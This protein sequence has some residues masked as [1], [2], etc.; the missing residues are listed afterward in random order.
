MQALP[1]SLCQ[2]VSVMDFEGSSYEMNRCS[3]GRST[4][5]MHESRNVGEDDVAFIVAIDNPPMR[6][7][8]L[9]SY[10]MPDADGRPMYTRDAPCPH[11]SS[12]QESEGSE[13]KFEL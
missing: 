3:T 7:I 5:G 12:R 11:K 8:V 6:A 4:D 2:A 10:N 13:A 9:D 1:I